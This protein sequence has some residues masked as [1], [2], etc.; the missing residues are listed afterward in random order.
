MCNS[1][2]YRHKISQ[3]S[4]KREKRPHTKKKEGKKQHSKMIEEKSILWIKKG[5][6]AA[7]E[8][9]RKE[10]PLGKDRGKATPEKW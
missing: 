6:K 5:E 3:H 1:L 8:K 10:A 4:K 2:I 7:R 9:Y